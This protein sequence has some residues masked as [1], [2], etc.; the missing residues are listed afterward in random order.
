M[1]TGIFGK[2]AGGIGTFPF[3]GGFIGGIGI[4]Y[5]PGTPGIPGIPGIPCIP[6]IPI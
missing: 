6:G 1:G 5:K 3:M 2:N 4:P